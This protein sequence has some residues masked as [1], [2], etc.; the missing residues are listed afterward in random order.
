M[1]DPEQ[2]SSQKGQ[3]ANHRP[4]QEVNALVGEPVTTS[5]T[6]T[7]KVLFE[8]SSSQVPC[9]LNNDRTAQ[10]RQ[11][12]SQPKRQS[13]RRHER[14]T[15]N[16]K[17]R[18]EPTNKQFLPLINGLVLLSIFKAANHQPDHEVNALVANHRPDQ[19][20]NAL[21]GENVPTFC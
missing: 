12:A 7:D 6:S 5:T 21:V 4:D 15:T 2:T 13:I 11:A 3:A 16:N 10:K 14:A 19:E 17:Q 18:K 9:S 8:G 1:T 20:V